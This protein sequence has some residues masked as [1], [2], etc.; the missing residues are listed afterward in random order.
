MSTL[1][2]IR[3]NKHALR[4]RYSVLAHESIEKK[5]GVLLALVVGAI[6]AAEV[7]REQVAF[8]H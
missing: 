2:S 8:G 4:H 6:K 1:M 7:E 5:T 3:I